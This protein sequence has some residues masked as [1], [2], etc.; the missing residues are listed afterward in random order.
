MKAAPR[1]IGGACARPPAAAARCRLADYVELTKP[2]I[3]VL[4][5]FTVGRGR[6]LA[7]GAASTLVLLARLLGTALVAAGASALNQF[8]ERTATPCMRRDREPPLPAGRL[9]P[10]EVLASAWCSPS[11]APALP[12]GR[13]CP[14]A[15]RR[16][17]RS[18]SSVTSSSTRR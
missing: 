10:L 18:P 3:A 6:L 4:V 11:P 7:A 15:G 13:G 8:L 2:R 5:L 1:R 9:Q 14:A 12:G 16:W 17:R